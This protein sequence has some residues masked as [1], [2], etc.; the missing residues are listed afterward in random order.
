MKQ[1]IKV[2]THFHTDFSKFDSAAFVEDMV[3]R[4]AELG[5]EA[6]A[7]SEHG[8]M[9]S[10]EPFLD[11][12]K[13]H[14][15]QPILGVEA[16][17]QEDGEEGRSHLVLYAKNMDGYHA[18]AKAVSASNERLDASGFP[19]MNFE[20]LERFFGK[21]SQGEG[22]VIATT[23]CISGPFARILLHD[24]FL[25]EKKLRLQEN[26]QKKYRFMDINQFIQ[27]YREKER[28]IEAIKRNVKELQEEKRECKK[29]AE[30]KFGLAQKRV[31][32]LK[33]TDTYEGAKRELEAEKEICA[34][35]KEKVRELEAQIKE[36]QTTMRL[37]KKDFAEA[38]KM[39][40]KCEHLQQ[41]CQTLTENQWGREEMQNHF[42][43]TL[44]RFLRIFGKNLWV[45]V[46]NHGMKEEAMVMPYLVSVA[47]AYQLQ[48]IAANDA[49]MVY[50]TPR[51]IYA[52]ECMKSL[53]FNK[54]SPCSES[55]K[56]LYIKT[57][58]E[59][60]HALLGLNLSEEVVDLAM[61]GCVR[62]KD[63]C[64][65]EFVQENHYPKFSNEPGYDANKELEMA[66]WKGFYEKI[67][68][69]TKEYQERMKY[70]IHI[71]QSMGYSDYHLIVKDFLEVGRKIGNLPKKKFQYLKD[72]VLEMDYQTFMEFIDTNQTYFGYSIGPGRGSAAGS[73][74]CYCLGITNLDPIE[75]DLLFERFLNPERVS[76]PDIDSDIHTEV[77][78]ILIEY[79]KKKYGEHSVCC[80]MTEGRNQTK[81]SVRSAGRIVG[82]RYYQDSAA[83]YSVADQIGKAIPD[84]VKK[85][86]DC[87]ED[88]L[89][90]FQG[91]KTVR[92]I[93]DTAEVIQGRLFTHGMHAAGV[94]ISD[95]GDIRE[96]IPLMYNEA[97]R[98]FTSQC[99][100]IKIEENGLLKMDFLG[101]KNL[102][103]ITDA[104]RL[105]YERTGKK[106]NLDH[107]DME[108]RQVYHEI[109]SRGDTNSV[110]QVESNGMKDMLRKFQPESFADICLL[111]AM[112][113]PGPM[114][115][116]PGVIEVKHGRK[117]VSYAATQLKDILSP[118]YG[119][120]VYQEQVQKI[121]QVLAG[122]SL[123]QADLVRRA[124]SKKKD[125][126]LEKERAAFVSGD[127]E[128]NIVGCL[129][130]G[131]SEEVANKLFDQ[132]KDFAKY[133]FNKSHAA[134]YA[135]TS[136]I[137]AY[138]K[139]YYPLEYLTAVL[140]HTENDKAGPIFENILAYGYR[141]LP[142]DVNHSM[143]DFTLEGNDVRF[144][145]SHIP[146]I[147]KECEELIKERE[148]EPFASYSDF[149]LRVKPKKK[150]F[151]N[152][153]KTG[154]FDTFGSRK[155]VIDASGFL[156]QWMKEMD[157]LNMS[158]EK[159]EKAFLA[160]KNQ[161]KKK[162][163]IE[164]MKKQ[165]QLKRHLE[166]DLEYYQIPKELD[167][168]MQNLKDEYELLGLFLGSHP[169]NYVENQGSNV[170]EVV[171]Q[172]HRAKEI[173]TMTGLVLNVRILKT[174]KDQ[175]D[176][177]IFDF[178]DQSHKIQV[179]CFPKNYEKLKQHLCD[180]SVLNIQCKV[181]EKDGE[182]QYYLEN[183][184]PTFTSQTKLILE[185][186]C[187]A[188]WG[189]YREM[190]EDY[191][192]DNG[193]Q[194]LIYTKKERYIGTYQRLV[195]SNILKDQR[196]VMERIE[197]DL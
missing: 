75:N 129:A 117:K 28:R 68:H 14:Q 118:T 194:L 43:D 104:I 183:V 88:L 2:L 95:N 167:D 108:D 102:D 52:R 139:H 4:G 81:A 144:G 74:V 90:E 16:Y 136:Y 85:I 170:S 99:D 6:M 173:I 79:V 192:V 157:T 61:A 179:V 94:V 140:N 92:A 100:M 11:A 63:E 45:E 15:I 115:F 72:H 97:N 114:E 21:G 175:K 184:I 172:P 176:F 145:L 148:K 29:R 155:G 128:R 8:V 146:N 59:L 151:D 93:L 112:Y 1:E 189:A 71:I 91:D 62:L 13:A 195:S 49:H 65:M 24:R 27:I 20:I 106:I 60:K 164:T 84:S 123:G 182:V 191:R 103:I 64:H 168:V 70:E 83:L 40:T 113:R 89:L 35:A 38:K 73:L 96:Y 34:K 51:D 119:A 142:P 152:L 37:Q 41:Q 58:A 185:I 143:K 178:G 30:R 166:E 149:Y 36:L 147:G 3:Q 101:L 55:E 33:G 105:I 44:Y 186:P 48:L 120:I 54:W 160:E 12:C 56:Q 124:M 18:I 154:G 134:V 50:G 132:M 23:A 86:E 165:K 66:A 46:Q 22:N 190:I 196:F 122:Y 197:T 163:L 153:L 67:K 7:I 78:P 77:R 181:G 109:Y 158:I 87:K 57:D 116:I 127:Q 137:T 25:E 10:I 98:Q 32:K 121:F 17:L 76:M 131:I 19:R 47:Q 171:K 193:C 110:F 150:L 125:K 82:S 161:T 5:A 107:L 138:L 126:L 80:I 169:M 177:A 53:R 188:Q 162:K 26:F 31:D 174:R 135:K 180:F 39:Y 130:N 159:N 133:A 156:K 42:L 141:V 69:P 9:T 187:Y 111:V